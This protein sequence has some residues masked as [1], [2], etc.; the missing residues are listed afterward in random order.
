MIVE[1]LKLEESRFRRTLERGLR[2]LDEETARLGTGDGWPARWR[3]SST[4]PTAFPS[5]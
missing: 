5:T 3:S 4:T 2:I 1:T